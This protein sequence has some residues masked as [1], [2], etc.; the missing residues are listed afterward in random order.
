MKLPS[1]NQEA[2]Q[3]LSSLLLSTDKNTIELGLQILK[4]HLDCLGEVVHEL[5]LLSQLSWNDEQRL[6]ARQ[7]LEQ[8]STN[9]EI[10][11]WNKVFYVFHIYHNLFETKD[12]EDNWHW[13]EY[14]EAH[15]APFMSFI[16]QNHEYAG[17]YIALAGTLTEYY[18]KRLDWAERYYHI[19]L[20]QNPNDLNLLSTLANL[21]QD[22]FHDYE[23]AL[24]YYNKILALDPA[25][26]DALEAKG[27]LYFDYIKSTTKAINVFET[28]L[29]Y[30]PN[31]EHLRIHLADAYMI[32]AEHKAYHKGKQMIQEI[33]ERNPT[34]SFAWTIYANRLWT[35]ENKPKEAEKAYI[36]CL[37]LNPRNYTI[38]GNL[39]ELH[40]SVYHDYEKAKDYYVKAFAIYMDDAFHLSNFISMLVLKTEELDDAKD[41]YQH[42]QS[43]F[44][45]PVRRDPEL[46]NQQWKNF[47][48]AEKRLKKH[49]P[50]LNFLA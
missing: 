22:G 41:Y 38:L 36:N 7:L 25:H 20:Q 13:F 18:K 15:R 26:Y 12:F 33:L 8:Q 31:D 40:E 21:Y 27:T 14:H 17:E 9:D 2:L 24:Y 49:F 32:K 1:L 39:A 30:H 11:H 6:V 37:N 50:S 35:T 46:N 10:E 34:S 48:I 3:H 47:Q 43:L 16:V 4:S 45:G 44:F 5:V 42:L 23:K 19:P 28:A 29:K